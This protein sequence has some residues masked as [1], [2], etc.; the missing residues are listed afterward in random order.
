[1]LIQA[2]H[3]AFMESPE[4]DDGEMASSILKHTNDIPQLI[5]KRSRGLNSHLCCSFGQLKHTS[6]MLRVAL[7]I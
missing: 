6:I 4:I 5:K 7:S 2:R 3:H 1:M